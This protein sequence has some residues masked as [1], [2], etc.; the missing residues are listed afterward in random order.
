[1]KHFGRNLT[2]RNAASASLMTGTLA[3]TAST[4]TRGGAAGNLRPAVREA[5][6]LYSV[7]LALLSSVN[8]VFLFLLT[9]ES[10][11]GLWIFGDGNNGTA[12]WEPDPNNSRGT[13]AILSTC[14]IT[15]T[16]CVYTSLH[17]NVPAHR[18]SNTDAFFRKAKY[19]IF[20]LLAPELI[21][22]NAWRQRTVASSLVDRVRKE[23][24]GK[25]TPS[26]FRRL[27][28]ERR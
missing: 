23:R 15:L 7:H 3:H 1:M 28:E 2:G 4:P 25:E 13:W 19:V 10:G 9:L 12:H 27:Y 17:L 18:S 5:F 6:T 24:G 14:I 22:F 21:A 26:L 20:G 8:I 16:L 11:M